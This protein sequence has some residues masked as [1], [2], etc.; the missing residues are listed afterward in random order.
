[1]IT[2]CVAAVK[3]AN[4]MR[5]IIRKGFLNKTANAIMPYSSLVHPDLECWFWSP[6]LKKDTAKVHKK[7][8]G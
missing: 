2:R 7:A 1:M 6:S 5:G 3:K 8:P 4:T